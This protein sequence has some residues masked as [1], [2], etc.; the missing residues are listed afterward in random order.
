MSLLKENFFVFKCNK[1]GKKISIASEVFENYE[2]INYDCVACSLKEDIK[3]IEDISKIQVKQEDFVLSDTEIDT[4]NNVIYI[5]DFVNKILKT[6]N[7]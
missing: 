1:C 7:I 6:K 4:Y 5:D 3:P 2:N